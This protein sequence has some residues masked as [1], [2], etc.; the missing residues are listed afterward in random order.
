MSR[1][2]EKIL[3]HRRRPYIENLQNDPR[4]MA[5]MDG[6]IAQ[7]TKEAELNHD[8]CRD[9]PRRL[10]HNAARRALELAMSFVLDNDGEYQGVCE[11]RDQL[12]DNAL[13]LEAMRPPSIVIP[14]AQA[15][16]MAPSVEISTN[17][18]SKRSD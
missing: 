18:P 10:A 16:T 1:F 8:L 15:A 13:K 12:L 11:Q 9:D 14:R 7:A 6:W 3:G 2:S 4:T 17:E 5:M